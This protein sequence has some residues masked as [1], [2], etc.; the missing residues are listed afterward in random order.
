MDGVVGLVTVNSDVGLDLVLR[1]K[2]CSKEQHLF[3]KLLLNLE[4]TV[5]FNHNVIT[6]ATGH[7]SVSI[8]VTNRE[9]L[10]YV[11]NCSVNEE[12]DLIK[13]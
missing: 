9:S 12:V 8:F 7:A 6:S 3:N 2:R 11:L 10:L 4:N 1:V 13:S 5:V